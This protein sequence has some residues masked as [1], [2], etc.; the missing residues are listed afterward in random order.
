[1]LLMEL[2]AVLSA[3]GSILAH[4]LEAYFQR[5]HSYRSE[6]QDLFADLSPPRNGVLFFM[7]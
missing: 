4:R 2:G 5:S 6:S 1:M 3:F 7:W